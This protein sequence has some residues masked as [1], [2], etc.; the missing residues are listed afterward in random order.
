MAVIYQILKNKKEGKM[1]KAVET[2]L[3]DDFCQQSEPWI[4]Q[5]F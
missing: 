4:K 2:E 1:T 5:A 3:L